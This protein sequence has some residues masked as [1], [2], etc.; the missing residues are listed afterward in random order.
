MLII[1]LLFNFITE[2]ESLKLNNIYKYNILCLTKCITIFICIHKY[3]YNNK[4]IKSNIWINKINNN[5]YNQFTILV[6]NYI[7]ILKIKIKYDINMFLN[8]FEYII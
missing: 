8:L 6:N 5:I 3:I 1:V 4:H 2:Q 7:Y